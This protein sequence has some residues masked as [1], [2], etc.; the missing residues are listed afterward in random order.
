MSPHTLEEAIR[1]G[2]GRER[3]CL[4]PVHGDTNPSAS[5]NVDTKLWHCFSC[6]AGGRLTGEALLAEPDY[7]R[8]A[9]RLQNSLSQKIY[10]EGWL[11]Q[12]DARAVHPYWIER[13]DEPTAR[14][15]RL[16][17]DREHAA[18]TYPLRDPAGRVLGVVRRALDPDQKP[19]YKYPYGVDITK[20]LYG[21]THERK[22]LVAL[23]EGA[24]D[25]VACD[26]V[27]IPALALYGSRI[28][29]EQIR[30]IERMDP[31]LIVIATDL[32]KAGERAKWAIANAFKHKMLARLSWPRGW[33]KDV[34]EIG[35]EKLEEVWCRLLQ[36][37]G[38]K[39][40]SPSCRRST[41]SSRPTKL[42]FVINR[43]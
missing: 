17:Y 26:R 24:L 27:G 31:E 37:V 38:W 40:E 41:D 32:D 10:S 15:H 16:G 30:L 2:H 39:V 13:F 8:L 35:P 42:P 1:L 11:N 43:A 4:C 28:S 29:A 6:G 20:N 7:Y 33:G 5:V 34:D 25:A 36:S 21:Y 3:A 23:V 22:P 18:V 12:F 9:K 19:K 14:K